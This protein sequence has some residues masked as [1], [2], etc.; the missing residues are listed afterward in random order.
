MNRLGGYVRLFR[1]E[2]AFSAAS[3][4]L[5]TGL[6]V[7]SIGEMSLTHGLAALCVF[8]SALVNFVLNDLHDYE[9][10]SLNGRPDRPLALGI[11]GKE[12]ALV[13]AFICGVLA[14]GFSFLLPKDPRLMILV[15]L[16]FT[17]AYNVYL[18]RFIAFKNLFTGFANA[19]VV[20]VGA[21]VSGAHLDPLVLFLAVLGFLFSVSYEVMLDIA[22]VEGDR[23][24]G[25]ETIP[26]RYGLERA[27]LVSVLV[28]V[29]TMVLSPLPFFIG[30]ENRLRGDSLFLVLAL[31]SVVDRAR[32]LRGLTLDQSP[33]KV[34]ELKGRLFRNLQVSGLVYL[35]GILV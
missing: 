23:K 33:N 1:L 4:V 6:I 29:V 31:V 12:T 34:L 20:L 25:V 13:L 11:I 9:G 10:D 22:D 28:G 32:V 18:K 14:V 2:R 15:G 19:G 21:A 35:I 7:G 5:I 17:L 3:G 26:V 24:N 30:I 27:V 16:P 8:F